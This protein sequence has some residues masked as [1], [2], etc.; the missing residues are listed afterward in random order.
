MQSGNVRMQALVSSLLESF[1]EAR[2]VR[3]RRK[4]KDH[5]LNTVL[6]TCTF[7]LPTRQ[8]SHKTMC[9]GKEPLGS[10]VMFSRH[11]MTQDS[12]VQDW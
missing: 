1:E 5:L 11:G 9:R 8:H 3:N 7:H 4:V 10:L 6:N 12:K 2:D